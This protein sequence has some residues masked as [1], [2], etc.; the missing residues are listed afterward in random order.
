MWD[1]HEKNRSSML[2]HINGEIQ[3]TVNRHGVQNKPMAHWNE[4]PAEGG[5]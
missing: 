1:F 2:L 4:D 5:G 3:F